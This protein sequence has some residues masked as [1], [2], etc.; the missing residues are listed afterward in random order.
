MLTQKYNF[1]FIPLFSHYYKSQ[2]F[3]EK[4]V[5]VQTTGDLLG[6]S[7]RYLFKKS[8]KG[9]QIITFTRQFSPKYTVHLAICDSD[10]AEAAPEANC[11]SNGYRRFK[12]EKKPKHQH[13]H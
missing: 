11:E 5:P 10:T 8:P 13:V 9:Q 7:A 3:Y 2:V 6:N 1:P 12:K 4:D